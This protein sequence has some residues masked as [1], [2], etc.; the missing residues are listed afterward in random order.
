VEGGRGLGMVI[1]FLLEVV[2]CSGTLISGLLGV[3]K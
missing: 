1:V 3:G 2:G